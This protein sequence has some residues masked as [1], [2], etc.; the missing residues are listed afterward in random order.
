MKAAWMRKTISSLVTHHPSPKT[1]H[2]VLSTQ[3]FPLLLP[4]VPLLFAILVFAILIPSACGPQAETGWADLYR[5]RQAEPAPVPPASPATADTAQ[6]PADQAGV[7][8]HVQDFVARFPADDRDRQ[9]R[10]APSR[11]STPDS[12]QTS[13]TP[14]SE[15]PTA[16]PSVAAGQPTPAAP[17]PAPEQKP[18]AAPAPAANRPVVQAMR[19]VEPPQPQAE[20]PASPQPLKN[21]PPVA[22]PESRQPRVELIDVRPAPATATPASPVEQ[23]SPANQP[24][25]GPTAGRPADLTAVVAELEESVKAHPEH[26]DDQFRLRLL[27]LA[28]GQDEK[29]VGPVVAADPV[30]ANLTTA[31]FQVISTA[32]TA[33]RQPTSSPAPA[34]AA[35]DE[36]RRLLGQQTPVIIPKIALV[37]RVNSFGD[38]EA[39]QPP[40][41]PAGQGVHVYLYTEVANFRSEPTSDGRLRTLLAEKVEIFDAAGKVIWQQTAD[42]I[43]D[44]VLTPRRDF[45]IPLEIRLPPETPPGEYTLKVTI[46]DKLGATT[47]QQRMTLMI[48]D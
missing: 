32:K 44:K 10:P 3:H 24:V 27:Y 40:R 2:S 1:Q 34:L 47:D 19:P 31:L 6:E 43:E 23:A 38:Y 17:T 36:L 46:E 15:S 18:L 41:F 35:V 8:P 21:P 20:P 37:T 25:L 29:A 28:T 33:I 13:Q 12:A 11:S 22:S 42:T 5:A 14:S 26:L 48:G 4:T 39:V 7:D 45:F 16:A 9:G 30:Q